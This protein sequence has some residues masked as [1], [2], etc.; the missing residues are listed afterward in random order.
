MLAKQRQPDSPSAKDENKG[1][2]VWKEISSVF[3]LWEWFWL[4]KIKCYVK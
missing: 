3:T 4:S 1:S 2:G